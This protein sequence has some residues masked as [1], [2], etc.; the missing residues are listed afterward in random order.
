MS[1]AKKDPSFK[2]EVVKWE[3]SLH[4]AYLNDFRVAGGKPWAGGEIVKTWNVS[5]RDLTEAVPELR[6]L[7]D[8]AKAAQSEL[9][10]LR[11][12]VEELN[13]TTGAAMFLTLTSEL[14]ALREE[15]A[16]AK[17]I[18]KDSLGK[19]S[20]ELR[21]SLTA[22]EQR[23]AELVERLQSVKLPERKS[24]VD[25]FSTYGLGEVSGWN[26]CL[27]ALGSAFGLE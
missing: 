9:T 12:E 25:T 26:K 27:D 5:L 16:S 15:L 18:I 13:K 20:A 7:S 2:L 6:K 10:S 22:A 11:A 23:N 4:C 14:A 8:G 3:G 1:E 17:R 19:T 24:A 21:I